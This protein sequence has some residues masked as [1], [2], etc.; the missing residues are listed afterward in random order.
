VKGKDFIEVTL[1]EDAG[2]MEEVVVVGYGTM[3]KRDLTGAMMAYPLAPIPTE[4]PRV[5]PT[6][7]TT[8]RHHPC[9]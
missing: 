6:V 2:L 8:S 7:A 4:R 9:R 1:E 3:K 5:M